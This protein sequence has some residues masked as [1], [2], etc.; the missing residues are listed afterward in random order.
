MNCLHSIPRRR[1]RV[2]GSP[3][4]VRYP[5]D[6]LGGARGVVPLGSGHER[7]QAAQAGSVSHR[8]VAWIRSNAR[9]SGASVVTAAGRTTRSQAVSAAGRGAGGRGL[10]AAER[11]IGRHVSTPAGEG[12]AWPGAY[13]CTRRVLGH[14]APGVPATVP[15]LSLFAG[16]DEAVASGG[17]C[18]PSLM[19]DLQAACAVL[20]GKV[21]R[22]THVWMSRTRRRPWL[23]E[24]CETAS[25]FQQGRAEGAGCS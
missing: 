15:A 3:R 19:A 7:Y 10:G 24:D 1:V 23:H 13:R 20:P 12:F 16:S 4:L 18:Q 9:D 11:P 8:V 6:L 5:A 17:D 25:L 14:P 21:P 22:A 2:D